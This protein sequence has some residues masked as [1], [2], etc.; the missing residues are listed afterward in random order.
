[1]N[2]NKICPRCG[3]DNRG[4]KRFCVECGAKLEDKSTALDRRGQATPTSEAS[5]GVGS[6]V[7]DSSAEKK[8]R[9][10]A[11]FGIAEAVIY[12][13]LIVLVFFIPQIPFCVGTAMLLPG[14]LGLV[15]AKAE[16]SAF[17]DQHPIGCMWML[18]SLVGGLVLYG[19]L[20]LF[21]R[22]FFLS[23]LE[24]F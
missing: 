12:V 18:A 13:G 2:T 24:T 7:S 3:K 8:A 21:Q 1:M 22:P 17:F 15:L 19:L 11:W 6:A 20:W 9:A 4:N 23:A 16:G 14:V 5:A 10:L